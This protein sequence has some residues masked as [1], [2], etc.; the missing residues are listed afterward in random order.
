MT[1][2]QSTLTKASTMTN[3]RLRRKDLP[4]AAGH[5]QP[6]PKGKKE[7]N[8]DTGTQAEIGP[9]EW[10]SHGMVGH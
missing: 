9:A 7:N 6:D 3:R 4:R 10:T 8:D 5:R 1:Q 2:D